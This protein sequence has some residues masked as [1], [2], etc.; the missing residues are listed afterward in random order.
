MKSFAAIALFA[1]LAAQVFALTVNTPPSIVQCQP[2][3]LTWTDGT[4]PYFPSIIPGGQ[5]SATPLKSFDST[6]ATQLT[7]N[8]DIAAGTS[9]TIA[10]RDST[11]A[12]VYS[13]AVTIA[14]SSDSSCVNSSVSVSGSG[15]SGS[16]ATATGS[17][18][19]A[20]VSTTGA[21]GSNT[22]SA[23]GTA[24][25]MSLISTIPSSLGVSSASLA[26]A[27]SSLHSLSSA[28]STGSSSAHA[29]AGSAASATSS[30]ESSGAMRG[31]SMHA[32]GLAGLVGLVGAALL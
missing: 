13:D 32:V 31:S 26:G 4:A 16:G 25:G 17:S 3:L 19:A 5:V 10:L 18:A 7:W 21:S 29:S 6:S 28:K 1:S 8:V 23:T 15:A 9:I 20:S 27:S 22:R 24:S 14:S 11:G 12:Q 30:T 2:V